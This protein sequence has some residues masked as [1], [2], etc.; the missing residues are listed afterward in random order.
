METAEEYLARK[1]VTLVNNYKTPG[2]WYCESCGL[3]AIKMARK[4]LREGQSPLI[5][6]KFHQEIFAS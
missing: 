3:I 4:L 5:M 1:H 6:K 2:G